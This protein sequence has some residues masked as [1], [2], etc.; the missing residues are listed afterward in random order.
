MRNWTLDGSGFEKLL[1]QVQQLISQ[2][3][4]AI[5]DNGDFVDERKGSPLSAKERLAMHRLIARAAATAA[6]AH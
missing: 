4:L 6:T 3:G 1:E 5:D 2:G